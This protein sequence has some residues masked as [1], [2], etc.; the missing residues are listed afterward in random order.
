MNETRLFV[1][2]ALAK[3][4]PM[5]GHQL[6]RDARLDRADLWSRVRPGS[7]YSALHRM[8]DEGL[9]RPLRTEQSGAL[10]ARTVYEITGEGHR[11]LRALRDEAF[12]EVDIRPDP[13]DLA[14]AVSEDLDGELLRGYVEDRLA[15]LRARRS[16]LEHQLDRRWPDQTAADDL[17]VEHATL[18]IQAEIDWHEKVLAH[19]DK[20][21]TGRAPNR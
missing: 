6:R 11:E 2:A 9:I 19:I 8:A 17:V 20:L 15:A 13:V 21:D 1:L 14:L 18:R 3:R 5:H 4:G 12:S 10:P 16:T 7:L